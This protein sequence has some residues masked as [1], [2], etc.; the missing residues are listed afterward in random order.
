MK[1]LSL[2]T[3]FCALAL[4]LSESIVNAQPPGGRPGQG[5]GRQGG[6][7]GGERGPGGRQG[8]G[9]AG[10]QQT[11]PLL[12]IFDANGDG[13]LSSNE[14]DTAAVALR[15]LDQNRDGK[16][17]AEELRPAGPG[18][19]QGRQGGAGMQGGPGQRGGRQGTGGRP[20]GG[21]TQ[22]GGRPGG[23]GG[24]GGDRGGDPAQADAA[25]AKDMMSFDENRD[26]ALGEAE[27][28]EHMHKAF[29]IAD[30]NKDGLLD[31]EERLV[32]ASQFRRNKLNPTGDAPVNTPTQGRRP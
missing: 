21:G 18:G 24:G 28:P 30:A 29:A 4:L 19:Q 13:E 6:G 1:R 31:E 23:G 9:G 22:E 7:S 15:K 14:I 32:L 5:G 3:V 8:M 25:F 10:V 2:L 11:P 17:T 26:G 27:L 16:L 20:S 12:R